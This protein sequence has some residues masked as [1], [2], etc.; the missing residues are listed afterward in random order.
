MFLLY[1][2][3]VSSTLLLLD[4]VTIHILGTRLCLKGSFIVFHLLNCFLMPGCYVPIAPGTHTGATMPIL[5]EATI[6]TLQSGIR[7]HK[8]PEVEGRVAI[9]PLYGKL[10][11]FVSTH[12]SCK[13]ATTL[14]RRVHGKITIDGALVLMHCRKIHC[15]RDI[16]RCRSID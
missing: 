3:I 8:T 11:I 9:I 13:R 12:G 2:S 16:R 10:N 5:I 14:Q 7:L 15:C 1:L 4:I 6:L